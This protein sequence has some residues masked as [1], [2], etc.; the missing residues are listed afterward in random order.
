MFVS[1]FIDTNKAISQQNIDHIIN[2]INRLPKNLRHT[3]THYAIYEK[4]YRHISKDL[5]I[6][7]SNARKRVQLARKILHSSLN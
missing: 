5:D 7:E 4:P 3:M 1:I 2:A 6:S